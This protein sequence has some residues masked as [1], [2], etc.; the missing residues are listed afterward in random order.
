MKGGAGNIKKNILTAIS[1][2]IPLVVAAGLCMALGQV[3]D[4]DVR[5]SSAG[6]GYYLYKAGGYGM[7]LVVPVI[8][9]SKL[10][11]TPFKVILRFTSISI[12]SFLFRRNADFTGRRPD[13]AAVPYMMKLFAAAFTGGKT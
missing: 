12:R 13:D 2:M 7:N 4:S 1:Y 11:M 3:V 8:T 10:A 5:N 6:L 9:A